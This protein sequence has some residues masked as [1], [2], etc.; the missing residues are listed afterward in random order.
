MKPTC[1][2]N[3]NTIKTKSGSCGFHHPT[4]IN[5]VMMKRIIFTLF[6]CLAGSGIVSAQKILIIE[7]ASKPV[8][9]DGI[10]NASDPWAADKWIDIT[11]ISAGSTSTDMSARFQ[12]MYD[13]T[14]LYFGVKV[15]DA[16][17]FTGNPTTFLNDCVEFFIA[18][19]TASGAMGMYKIGDRQIRL[20][21]V[22][23]PL[24][25]GGLAESNFGVPPSGVYKC[26]DNGTNYVQEWIMPWAELSD[27]MDPAW[28]KKQFKFD[29]MVADA[30]VDGERTQ[31]MFWNDNSDLQWNNT[32]KFGIVQLKT[33]MAYGVELGTDKIIA[34]GDSVKFDPS[35]SYPNSGKI[36]Y[37][38]SPSEGL[39]ATDIL[40]PVAFT[41]T[42]KKYT[43]TITTPDLG[44]EKDSVLIKVNPLKATVNDIVVSCGNTA[45]LNLTTN[46]G[47]GNL[48]YSWSPAAGLSAT[49]IANPVVTLNSKADYSVEVNTLNGCT[50]S[51]NVS[52]NVSAIAY[53]PSICMV[54]VDE[55]DRNVVVIKKEQ[56][57]G[58]DAFFIYRESSLQ[59]DQYDLIGSLP[60]LENG[61]YI[62]LESNAKVQ[63][64]K[65]RI[66]VK[67][68][69]GFITDKSSVHKTMHLTIN[70]GSGNNW[71]LFWEPYAGIPVSGYVIYR[72]TTKS[73]LV[74]IGNSSG[75]NTS[76]TD[77]TAPEGDVYYQLEVVLPQPCI[78]L[79][80]TEYASVRSNIISNSDVSIEKFSNQPAEEF[81][82][83][84]PAFDKL[85]VRPGF[86]AKAIIVIYDMTGKKLISRQVSGQIDISGLSKGIYMVKLIDSGKILINKLL[87][88]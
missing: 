82:Y 52:V 39:N 54:T 69:C 16:N 87:K 43:L 21:A 76:Y 13:K 71:N 17:R 2:P 22:A 79:K 1:F 80:S 26:I 62:D 83:P 27:G 84:N 64:N 11:E 19:D 41:K 24:A 38:W 45:Q 32:T 50:A 66:A 55:N 63:S 8:V 58:V 49:N 65:Y 51:D 77:I 78:S 75:S 20:Q 25:P 47:L 5:F 28:D 34:C 30:T 68:I 15:N 6:V 59:T 7:P 72:G 31:L 33:P 67:D 60:Y 12:L 3:T 23:D 57:T 37:S 35:V 70:K 44:T 53:N 48:I 14:N 56:N 81:I 10:I 36:T 9:A 88:E 40:N 86:S 4:K 61:V 46:S 29:V 42:N 85:T 73:N 18:M 74:Q